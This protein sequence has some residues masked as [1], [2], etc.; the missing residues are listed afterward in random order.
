MRTLNQLRQPNPLHERGG[1]P[2]EESEEDES[3]LHWRGGH[4]TVDGE[5]QTTSELLHLHWRGGLPEAGIDLLFP[6]SCS[7]NVEVDRHTPCQLPDPRI[8]STNVEVSRG[9]RV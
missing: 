9:R 8:F 3:F 5:P 1:P 2:L 7:M 6:S 4:P